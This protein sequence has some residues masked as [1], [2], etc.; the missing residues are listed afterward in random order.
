[1][2]ARYFAKIDPAGKLL[3]VTMHNGP[4]ANGNGLSPISEVE[5]RAVMAGKI[6]HA[7][8][9]DRFSI[10]ERVPSYAELRR[11]AYPS[12]GDQLGALMAGGK[13]LQDMKAAVQAVKT[14][15][16]KPS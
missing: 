7:V 14:K 12:T 3:S 4:V 1:M 15:Y 13:E 9:N 6:V 10:E 11:A 2:S 16:P 5:Y 8:V